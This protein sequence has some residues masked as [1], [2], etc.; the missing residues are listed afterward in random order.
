LKKQIEIPWEALQMQF[1]AGY[2]QTAQ[3][4][5]NFKHNFLKQLRAVLVAYP[6]AKAADGSYGLLW[7][8]RAF[9]SL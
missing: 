2:S 4:Q 1:G 8:V 5:I 3:G 9:C 7:R 6:E